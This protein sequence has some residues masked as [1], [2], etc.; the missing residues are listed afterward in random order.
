MKP[1]LQQKINEILR[2]CYADL[3]DVT[4]TKS[5]GKLQNISQY[6]GEAAACTVATRFGKGL[7]TNERGNV[8]ELKFRAAADY[9]LGEHRLHSFNTPNLFRYGAM[10]SESLKVL[11]QARGLLRK[12]FRQYDSWNSSI[13]IPPGE[14]Y[15]PG[16]GIVNLHAKLSNEWS[17]TED[18]Y[19]A[20]VMLIMNT[21]YLRRMMRVKLHQKYG[22]QL[23]E[24]VQKLRVLC[25]TRFS[26]YRALYKPLIKIVDGSRFAS[27]PKDTK[28]RR[29][30]NIEP[31]G[32]ILLQY[33][34]GGELRRVNLSVG[35]D[36]NLGQQHHQQLCKNLDNATI[37]FSGASD[38]ISLELIK[39]LFC[40]NGRALL[41]LHEDILMARSPMV[42]MDFGESTNPFTTDSDPWV[43]LNKVS[44]MGNGFTFELLTTVLLSIA[45]SLDSSARVYGDD[46]IIRKDKADIFMRT[47]EEVGFIVNREKSFWSYSFRESCG[48]FYQE[49]YGEIL[50]F[51]V[52]AVVN[53]SKLFTALNKLLYL[54]MFYKDKR[55]VKA[56]LINS[57]CSRTRRQILH[58]V[59][60]KF[61]KFFGPYRELRREVGLNDKLT[62]VVPDSYIMIDPRSETQATIVV[63]R[64][65]LH[66]TVSCR[67]KQLGLRVK[68]CCYYLHL[69]EKKAVYDK[70]AG[71]ISDV[72]MIAASLYGSRVPILEKRIQDPEKR[73]RSELWVSTTDGLNAPVDSLIAGVYSE[74]RV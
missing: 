73:F 14:T 40:N 6:N 11:Y 5:L 31:L 60:H 69:V 12:W 74:I 45:R 20:F 64:E 51:E 39:F 47:C 54:A 56:K 61:D 16:Y 38:T 22:S 57:I 19:D 23:S 25:R 26:L 21:R 3:L 15:I 48:T 59:G 42:F 41:A 17:V 50:S 10:P 35:N 28:K 43:Y 29:P 9:L 8:E 66:Q 68:G 44:S 34:I 7:F 67:L 18:A 62:Y 13:K 37:D 65:G 2:T 36:L 72:A 1:I 71:L 24:V 58:C 32:N 63:R 49:G 52:D 55:D 30:I 46:V 70:P 33:L 27:V 53:D 4:S